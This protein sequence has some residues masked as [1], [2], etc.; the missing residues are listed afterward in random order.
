MTEIF[1]SKWSSSKR[2]GKL[3]LNLSILCDLLSI[4]LGQSKEFGQSW[5]SLSKLS[6]RSSRVFLYWL[7]IAAISDFSFTFPNTCLGTCFQK[8]VTI[9]FWRERGVSAQVFLRQVYAPMKQTFSID[10]IVHQL[11]T[12][13]SPPFKLMA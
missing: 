13:L 9:R 1:L 10:S 4:N 6:I 8:I 11:F 3:P 2:V 12:Y 5:D 7:G